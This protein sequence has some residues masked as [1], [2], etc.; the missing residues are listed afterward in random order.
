MIWRGYT[1]LA[2]GIARHQLISYSIEI[3]AKEAAMLWERLK[4]WKGSQEDFYFKYVNPAQLCKK[5]KYPKKPIHIKTKLKGG[6]QDGK[7]I[8][9]K[10]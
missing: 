8:R 10:D 2:T 6:N 5:I 9:N 1:H 3:T 7:K 4:Q